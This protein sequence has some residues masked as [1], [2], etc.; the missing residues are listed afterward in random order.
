MRRTA[1]FA[2]SNFTYLLTHWEIEHDMKVVRHRQSLPEFFRCH[3]F[4]PHLK[5]KT[6][7]KTELWGR[8]VCRTKS[9]YVILW[10]GSAFSFV[11]SVGWLNFFSF[12]CRK[13]ARDELSKCWVQLNETF[14][15]FWLSSFSKQTNKIIDVVMIF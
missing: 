9:F 12:F 10:N 3:N 13:V 14:D 11:F 5:K 2:F 6:F 1:D 15:T 7:Y 4:I 8:T